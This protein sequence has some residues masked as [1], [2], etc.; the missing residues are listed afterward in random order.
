MI[1][2]IIK[3]GQFK[4]FKDIF[5]IKKLLIRFL[6]NI[7]DKIKNDKFNGKINPLINFSNIGKEI[8][9]IKNTLENMYEKRR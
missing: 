9:A 3:R 2:P 1:K 7:R 8:N 6:N 5:F 4:F